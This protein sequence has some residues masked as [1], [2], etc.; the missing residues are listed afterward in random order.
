MIVEPVK[1]A[2]KFFTA[3]L[4]PGRSSIVDKPLP[5]PE[6]D[7]IEGFTLSAVDCDSAGA[8]QHVACNDMAA[9]KDPAIAGTLALV[10]W[11]EPAALSR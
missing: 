11:S 1:R 7:W 9:L 10:S 2:R 5:L 6:S 4:I 3:T 8:V